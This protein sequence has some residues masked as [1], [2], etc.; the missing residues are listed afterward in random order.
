MNILYGENI[1]YIRNHIQF[2]N[3]T[4]VSFKIYYHN[5][6]D[7]RKDLDR[8]GL[9]YHLTHNQWIACPTPDHWQSQ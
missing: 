4:P 6:Y 1:L 2:L 9:I 7:C 5:T 8:F 3:L